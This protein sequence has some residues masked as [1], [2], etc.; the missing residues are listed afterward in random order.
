M[1][2]LRMGEK[3]V[4]NKFFAFTKIVTPLFHKNFEV[5]LSINNSTFLRKL[6]N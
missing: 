1:V 2:K 6:K 4:L 5:N 3:Q